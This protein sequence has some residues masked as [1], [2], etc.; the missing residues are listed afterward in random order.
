[1]CIQ[2]LRILAVG[3]KI[4]P[5]CFDMYNID[6]VRFIEFNCHTLT[7]Y[8]INTFRSNMNI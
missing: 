1:M 2:K 5:Y 8:H 4:S 3:L 6:K 7:I